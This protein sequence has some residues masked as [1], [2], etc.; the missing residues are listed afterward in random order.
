MVK[1][2]T[3]S[4]GCAGQIARVKPSIHAPVPIALATKEAFRVFIEG[5][6]VAQYAFGRT[7]VHSKIALRKFAY[8][9]DEEFGKVWVYTVDAATGTL[10]LNPPGVVSAG[11]QPEFMAVHPSGQFAYVFNR[12][13]RTVSMYR[14]DANKIRDSHCPYP[15]RQRGAHA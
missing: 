2:K 12:Q 3:A 4:C 15:Y 9:S 6:L 5:A 14:I 1:K 7:Y 13:D 11:N 10:A 8:V